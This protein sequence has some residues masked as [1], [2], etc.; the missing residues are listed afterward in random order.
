MFRDPCF[1][2]T[3]VE[4]KFSFD[5]RTQPGKKF[6]HVLCLML[7]LQNIFESVGVMLW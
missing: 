5:N 3:S 6:I 1:T 7:Q 4:N 2:W